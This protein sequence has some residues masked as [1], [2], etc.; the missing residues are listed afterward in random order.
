MISPCWSEPTTLLAAKEM[1][2]EA[3]NET[4]QIMSKVKHSP[5]FRVSPM[6]LLMIAG[7]VWLVSSRCLSLLICW[8][9][10]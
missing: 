2:M 9:A 5:L 7:W 8:M 6:I 10:S 3:V 4:K 1:Q